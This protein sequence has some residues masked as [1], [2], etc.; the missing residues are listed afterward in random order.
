MAI[1]TGSVVIVETD[2][3]ADMYDVNDKVVS[4]AHAACNYRPDAAPAPP[5]P[6]VGTPDER[7][8]P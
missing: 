2:A 6:G 1:A 4:I 3:I 7:A 8:Q 5:E